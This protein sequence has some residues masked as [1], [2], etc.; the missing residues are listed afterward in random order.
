MNSDIYEQMKAQARRKLESLYNE[1]LYSCSCLPTESQGRRD[2]LTTFE[3]AR[4]EYHNVFLGEWVEV[5]NDK[6]V[7][8]TTGCY[9]TEDSKEYVDLLIKMGKLTPDQVKYLDSTSL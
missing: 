1:Y 9:V 5:K 3:G 7:Y 6:L 8:E 4:K 2:A